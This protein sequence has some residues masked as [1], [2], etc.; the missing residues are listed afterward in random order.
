MTPGHLWEASDTGALPCPPFGAGAQLEQ[1]GPF[2]DQRPALAFPGTHSPWGQ[3]LSRRQRSGL[4]SG[5]PS[6]P[7]APWVTTSGNNSK[8]LTKPRAGQSFVSLILQN[9]SI[10]GD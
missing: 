5:A 3:G 1:M 6:H 9:V 2:P 8:K 10:G 4:F 7:R